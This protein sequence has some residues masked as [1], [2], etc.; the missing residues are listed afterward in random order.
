MAG[1]G[2]GI[3][4]KPS[5]ADENI[6]AFCND[7]KALYEGQVKIGDMV[8]KLKKY[9]TNPRIPLTNGKQIANTALNLIVSGRAPDSFTR[10]WKSGDR[11]GLHRPRASRAE[12]GKSKSVGV[13][14]MI[15]VKTGPKVA[16]RTSSVPAKPKPQE[17][18]GKAREV[19]LALDLLVKEEVFTAAEAW[20]ALASYTA[21]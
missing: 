1:K 9:W 10:W 17:S 20:D 18:G 6:P 12:G 21:R 19:A 11:K 2:N 15:H 4:M 5:I 16:A 8:P 3:G 13:P 7:Y 14:T